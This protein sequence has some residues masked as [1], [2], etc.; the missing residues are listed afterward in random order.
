LLD[1]TGK[2]ANNIANENENE[3]PQRAPIGHAGPAARHVSAGQESAFLD[4]K[5]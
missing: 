2:I 5:R 3:L 1:E 4:R